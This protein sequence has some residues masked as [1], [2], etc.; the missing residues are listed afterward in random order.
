MPGRMIKWEKGPV[1]RQV[2]T[3]VVGGDV[4]Q[5]RTDGKI[6]KAAA[7]SFTV[8]GV[9]LAD[10]A[11]AASGEGT[12]SYGAPVLDISLPGD[13]VAVARGCWV[14][15]SYAAAASDGAKLIAAANGTVTPAGAAPDARSVIGE[16]AQVGGMAGA[17]VGLAYIY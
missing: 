14:K 8:I 1:T 9:A 17:G 15:V 5:V 10:A 3:A 6:E 7:G 16:C 13:R 2:N 4:V 11:P 12:T